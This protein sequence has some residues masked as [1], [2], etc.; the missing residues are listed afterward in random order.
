[1]KYIINIF[2]IITLFILFQ[3]NNIFAQ[4]AEG[5]S[6]GS[7][8]VIELEVSEIRIIIEK[9]QVTL[10]SD[11][12]KPEFDDVNLEKSF[13]KEIIGEGERFVFEETKNPDLMKKIDI[14]KML[15]KVR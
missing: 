4:E 8:E 15:K 12:I 10:F 5:Q 1:M 9:P 14:D 6:Y 13:L 3:P 2:F 7:E 11:R